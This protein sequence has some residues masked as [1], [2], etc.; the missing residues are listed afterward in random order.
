MRIG[1]LSPLEMIEISVDDLNLSGDN[2][3]SCLVSTA[4][5]GETG[6]CPA[7]LYTGNLNFV[8]GDK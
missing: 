5:S 4:E 2:N 1:V 6:S 3:N 8:M 7:S